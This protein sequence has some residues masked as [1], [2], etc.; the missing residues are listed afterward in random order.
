MSRTRSEKKFKTDM[1]R[2]TISAS[3]GKVFMEEKSKSKYQQK[4]FLETLMY[5]G[6]CGF[7]RLYTSTKNSGSEV[8]L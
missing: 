2:K 6:D 1:E 8:K 4:I 3:R 5:Q 7:M